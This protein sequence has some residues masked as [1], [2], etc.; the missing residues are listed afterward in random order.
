[1]DRGPGIFL[2]FYI[3]INGGV[4]NITININTMTSSWIC[5]FS[6]HDNFAV[7]AIDTFF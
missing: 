4:A 7:G 3:T 6:S 2:R 5:S 1:M